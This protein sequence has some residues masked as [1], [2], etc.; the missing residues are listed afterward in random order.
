MD[1]LRRIGQF[2][3]VLGG[4]L[5]LMFDQSASNPAGRE[6][7]LLVWGILALM[8]GLYLVIKFRRRPEPSERF[9]GIKGLL[10]SGSMRKK[11]KDKSNPT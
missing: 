5:F 7:R 9:S 8:T 3:L 6:E 11:N 2:L 10:F 1:T 4:L